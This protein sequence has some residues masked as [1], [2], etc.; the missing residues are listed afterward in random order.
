M[1]L[2]SCIDVV[3]SVNI[4]HTISGT[5]A[6]NQRRDRRQ[7]YGKGVGIDTGSENQSGLHAWL[8]D[9]QTGND[10]RVKLSWRFALQQEQN[11]WQSISGETVVSEI[12]PCDLSDSPAFRPGWVVSSH[13]VCLRFTISQRQRWQ[14]TNVQCEMAVITSACRCS[15]SSPADMKL[16]SCDTVRSLLLSLWLCAL[17]ASNRIPVFHQIRSS[18]I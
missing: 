9:G 4:W 10:R 16:N 15:V 14:L 8:T 11:I 12:W 3:S 2:S 6:A 7:G 18:P 1:Y 13:P 5:L 17:S